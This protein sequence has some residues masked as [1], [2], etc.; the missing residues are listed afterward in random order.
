MTEL[1]ADGV[2]RLAQIAQEHDIAFLRVK[3]GDSEL[4]V[5]RMSVSEMAELGFGD[6]VGDAGARWQLQ[7]SRAGWEVAAEASRGRRAESHRPSGS[8]SA[9]SAQASEPTLTEPAEGGK[10]QAVSST[11]AAE[12]PALGGTIDAPMVG[13]FYRASSPEEPPFVEPGSLVEK[14]T[15]VGLIEAMKVF[16]AVTSQERGIVSE[17]LVSN[18]TFVEFGQPLVRLDPATDGL[19]RVKSVER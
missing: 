1:D 6:M 2:F 10:S 7:S 18:G 8:R 4:V 9:G 11:D 17:V 3:L 16:T 15:T 13:I 14:G 12:R 19:E 5:S